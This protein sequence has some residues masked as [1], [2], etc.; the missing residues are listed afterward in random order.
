MKRAK[1]YKLGIVLIISSFL[2]G[3]GGGSLLALIYFYTKQSI[4]IAASTSIYII[5]W[6]IFSIGILLSG[7][8]S[9][10]VIKQKY[11]KSNNKEEV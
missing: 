11:F 3:Y 2:I 8:D 6:C 9:L 1:Y 10:A 7:K 5:S 4:W